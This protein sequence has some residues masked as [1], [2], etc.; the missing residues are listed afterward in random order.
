MPKN[1]SRIND[2][3]SLSWKVE[4]AIKEAIISG[5]YQPREQLP[6]E[7]ELSNQFGVS[8]PVVREAMKSLKSRGFLE[9]RRGK[10]G[11]SYIS[12]LDQLFF[13]ENFTDLIRLK[14]IQVD[15]LVQARLF[16]EPE[17][18]KLVVANA[19]DQDLNKIQK[20]LIEFEE[21]TDPDIRARL[22]TEYHKLI[23]RSCGNPFYSVLMDSIMD[24]YE[25]YMRVIK[26]PSQL[27]NNIEDHSKIYQAIKER[28]TEKAVRLTKRHITTT[29]DNRIKMEKTYLRLVE[30]Q[31]A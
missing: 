24:F 14:K 16:I 1:F 31:S 6:V 28:D 9:I 8:R 17:V 13:K 12:D 21:T 7:I 30:K 27:L 18:V 25:A 2:A 4:K 22:V 20:N 29:V 10:G 26:P 11:G 15:D 23:G 3:N 19:T 5:T